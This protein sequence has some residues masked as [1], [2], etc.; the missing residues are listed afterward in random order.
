MTDHNFFQNAFAR[1]VFDSRTIKKIDCFRSDRLFL[2]LNCLSPGQTQR[3]HTH[4]G[5]DKFYLVLQGKARITVGPDTNE[6]EPGGIVWVPAG[7]SHGIE[8]ALDATLVL[9]GMAPP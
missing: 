3:Q 9:V 1:A 2:G 5:A 8:E 7:M 6:V 4:D